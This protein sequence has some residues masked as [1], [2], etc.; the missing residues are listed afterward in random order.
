MMFTNG[1]MMD[2]R[3]NQRSLIG[4]LCNIDVRSPSGSINNRSR[5]PKGDSFFTRNHKDL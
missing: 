3:I 5:A 4:I 1:R 2:R